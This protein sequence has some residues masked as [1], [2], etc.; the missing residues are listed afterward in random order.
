MVGTAR[1]Q[2]NYYYGDDVSKLAELALVGRQL[3]DHSG[4][5]PADIDVAL[6][7]DHFSPLVLLQLEALGFCE[8]GSAKHFVGDGSIEIGGKLPVTRTAACSAKHTS[9]E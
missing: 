3:W 9:T 2:L 7:Y 4:L 8:R 5:I 6:L 1:L